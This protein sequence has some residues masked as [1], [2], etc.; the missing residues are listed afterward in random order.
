LWREVLVVL[1][2]TTSRINGVIVV[3]LSGGIFFGEESACLRTLVKDLLKESRQ[4][5]FDLEN[6]THLDSGGV[7]TLV[8]VYTSAKKV[9]GDVKFANLGNHTK[10]VFQATNLVTVFEIFGKTRDAIASFKRDT[11]RNA[12]S[13]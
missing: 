11:K 8:A 7:G 3:Y 10:E 1:N 4:I 12:N 6:V 9:G 5:V 2:T 13:P